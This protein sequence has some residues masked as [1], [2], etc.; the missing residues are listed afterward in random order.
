MMPPRRKIPE[1]R[2][3]ITNTLPVARINVPVTMRLEDIKKIAPDFTFKAFL[4][5]PLEGGRDLPSQAE[6]TNGDGEP[7]TLIFLIDL[8]PEARREVA[9][10]YEPKAPMRLTLGYDRRTF[11]GVFPELG[12][13]AWESEKIVYRLKA[14]FR[15]TI[16]FAA[17][18]EE[19]LMLGEHIKGLQAGTDDPTGTPLEWSDCGGFGVWDG[20]RIYKP[21]NPTSSPRDFL[22]VLTRVIS[23]GPVRS[24]V[25]VIYDNWLIGDKRIRLSST[26]SITAGWGYSLNALRIDGGDGLKV[27]AMIPKRGTVVQDK[28]AGLLMA[29]DGENQTG[30]AVIFPT[31]AFVS[32][33]DSP[34]IA[35]DVSGESYV[36][37]LAPDVRG[38]VS[39]YLIGRRGIGS[40]EEFESAVKL[41]SKS[42]AYPPEIKITPKPKVRRKRR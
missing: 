27:A 34:P 5:S 32:F 7:D 26:L 2:V 40:F 11:A 30:F 17:K 38:K 25:Q 33:L 29:W 22:R 4:A 10:R 41:I 31:E 24:S 13:V 39:Y 9:V 28:D 36:V 3:I 12:G 20:R 19:R 42:I 6:D 18:S 14:D 8:E 35:P 21:F 23:D 1:F 16:Q 37:V 15:A